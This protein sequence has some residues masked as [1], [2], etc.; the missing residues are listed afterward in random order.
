LCVDGFHVS[1]RKDDLE[2]Y[3][4]EVTLVRL[5]RPDLADLIAGEHDEE[6]EAALAQAREKRARLEAFYD[7][8][9]AGELTPA[10]LSRIE[11][12]LLPEIEALERRAQA[13]FTSPLVAAIAGPNARERWA[14]LT[15][16]Q[17]REVISTL[18]TVRIMP[19]VRGSRDF[20]P[21]AIEVVW[22]TT[23]TDEG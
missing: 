3:I 7:A 17:R 22:R 9:A 5:E 1:R 23:T 12:R 19:T 13:Q 2:D 6:T 11:A 8:A 14:T 10:A 4:T 15:L 16:T 21:E 18:M 20:R